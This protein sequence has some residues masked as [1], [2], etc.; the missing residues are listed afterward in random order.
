MSE[1][2]NGDHFSD[3]DE[4]EELQ[5]WATLNAIKKSGQKDTQPLLSRNDTLSL[6][7]YDQTKLNKARNMRFNVLQS[8]RGLV[9]NMANLQQSVIYIDVTNVDH[10]FMVNPKGKFLETMGD[11]DR[12]NTCHLTREEV[13]Y[14][15]E[16]G[17]CLARAY[18]PDD[19]RNKMYQNMPPLSLQLVYGLLITDSQWMDKY[20][21]YSLLKRDGYIVLSCEE[22]DEQQRRQQQQARQVL[23]PQNI[24]ERNLRP[25][26]W[27]S[28][29]ERLCLPFSLSFSYQNIFQWL[30]M[31]VINQSVKKP[32]FIKLDEDRLSINFNVW[33]PTGTFKKK[34]KQL[35]DYQI[36]IIK[37]HDPLPTM[38]QLVD[39]LETSKTTSTNTMKREWSYIKGINM[40]SLKGSD[41]NITIAVVDDSIVNFIKFSD[42]SFTAEGVVWRDAWAHPKQTVR[43][44]RKPKKKAVSADDD[45]SKLLEID[46]IDKIKS[47]MPSKSASTP[48]LLSLNT[49]RPKTS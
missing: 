12:Y 29:W 27:G 3:E 20:M 30:H 10:L 4:D 9:V 38:A 15:V 48:D 7:E 45:T 19:N 22:G 42:C 44:H 34:N 41:V 21:V 11:I 5:D 33:K 18:H 24:I 16:R 36:C 37:A 31:K 2:A 28:I 26:W 47:S 32:G 17:S 23:R 13:V 1:S 14:L 49:S 25:T 39:L 6:S 46:S 35:P 8:K 40:N 43:N